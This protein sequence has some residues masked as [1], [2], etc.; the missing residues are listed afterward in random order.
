M[1]QYTGVSPNKEPLDVLANSFES[2]L[3]LYRELAGCYPVQMYIRKQNV[4]VADDIRSHV[5][6]NCQ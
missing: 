1:N 4:R 3:R 2:A 5:C 6:G